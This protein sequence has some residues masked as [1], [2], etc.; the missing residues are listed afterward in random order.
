MQSFWA[1]RANPFYQTK[2]YPALTGFADERCGTLARLF[3]YVG[4]LALLAIVSIYLWDQL[5]VR[6]A[7]EPAAR[8]GWSLAT[9]SHPAFAVSQ[10]DLPEKAE[11]NAIF[12]HPQGGRKDVLRWTAQ[13]EKPVAEPEIYRPGGEFNPS[14]PAADIAARMG[15][16][17]GRDLEAVGVIDIKFGPGHCSAIPATPTP[18]PASASSDVSTS[19]TCRSPAGPARATPCRPGAPSSAAF[20][21]G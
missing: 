7:I 8:P 12:R 17:G 3:A 11:A 15:P 1:I 4:T 18:G 16:K 14:G 21:T 10:F 5:P 13:G 9:R 19:P 2:I 6:E 20:W